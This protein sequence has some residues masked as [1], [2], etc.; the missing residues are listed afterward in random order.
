L[1]S[2][3]VGDQLPSQHCHVMLL[4]SL[5]LT[6]SLHAAKMDTICSLGWS[7]GK[8]CNWGTPEQRTIPDSTSRE[9]LT[10]HSP[11]LVDSDHHS[12]ETISSTN[13]EQ[14]HAEASWC[15]NQ[16][17]AASLSFCFG[18][19][20][21]CWRQNGVKFHRVIQ[22]LSIGLVVPVIA[23]VHDCCRKLRS[24]TCFRTT[25]RSEQQLA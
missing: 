12:G 19:L 21:Q 9:D 20:T 8:N 11:P 10:L 7:R 23:T 4:W 1:F 25:I 18:G 15:E 3:L 14:R 6:R 5:C 2:S 22:G 17:G 24:A 13:N 16:G